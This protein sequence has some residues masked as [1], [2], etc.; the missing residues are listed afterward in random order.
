VVCEQVMASREEGTGTARTPTLLDGHRVV[1][2]YAEPYRLS[3]PG[4]GAVDEREVTYRDL[5][6]IEGVARGRGDPYE[7]AGVEVAA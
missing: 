4:H 5:S 6:C 7:P 1:I 2:G 3:Q